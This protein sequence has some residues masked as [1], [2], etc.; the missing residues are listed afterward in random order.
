[1]SAKIEEF[2]LYPAGCNDA[3]EEEVFELSDLDHIMP[4]MYVQIALTF[5]L[6]PDADKAKIVENMKAGLEMTL[7]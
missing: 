4:K 2:R 3:P 5:E 6:K 7:K 1:M